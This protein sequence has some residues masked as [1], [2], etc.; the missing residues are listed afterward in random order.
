MGLGK[1][2][3]YIKTAALFIILPFLAV[4]YLI[5]VLGVL[6]YERITGIDILEA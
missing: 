4:F 5:V 3:T 2:M 6:L 1:A